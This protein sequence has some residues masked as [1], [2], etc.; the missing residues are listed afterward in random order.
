MKNVKQ[1]KTCFVTF[2][3]RFPICLSILITIIMIG[4]IGV[5]IWLYYDQGFLE[6]RRVAFKGD[7]YLP[8]LVIEYGNLIPLMYSALACPLLVFIFGIAHGCRKTKVTRNLYIVIAFLASGGLLYCGI[9]AFKHKGTLEDMEKE[10]CESD[11][12]KGLQREYMNLVNY[13]MCSVQCP[14]YRGSYGQS[15]TQW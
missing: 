13:P 2:H 5:A 9:M 3:Q 4:L 7:P 10:L 1:V 6:T 8:D 15:K 11:K 14:C 12:V